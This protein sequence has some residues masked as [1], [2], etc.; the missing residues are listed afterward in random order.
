MTREVVTVSPTDTVADALELIRSHNIRHLP[1]MDA[2]R[3]VGVVT[4]RDLRLAISP[5]GRNAPEIPVEDVMSSSPIT[6]APG[7]PIE[8]A[9]E[10]LTEHRIGCIPVLEDGE[11][12]GILA[13]SDLLRAFVELMS[14]R[15]RHSRL[16][17]MAP[18]RPGELARIVR[19]VGIDH[20]V[21]ITGVVVPP[22]RGPQALVILHL[23]SDDV[24]DVLASL[25]QLGYEAGSPALET[26][27]D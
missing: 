26:R 22:P 2:G 1:V 18:D 7:T 23:E 6:V 19:L 20:G 13:E 3:L 21:N 12:V 24:D 8:T 4:D 14:G 15:Q 25:R 16:E 9:A 10:I 27:S 17:L 5:D 11:L